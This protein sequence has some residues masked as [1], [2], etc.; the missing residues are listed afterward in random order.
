[1]KLKK[2]PKGL[3]DV[4]GVS[5]IREPEPDFTKQ[6]LVSCA[7]IRPDD[8]LLQGG[9]T[10][11]DVRARSGLYEDN[12]KSDPMDLEGYVDNYG[13]FLDRRRASRVAC[14][15][16]QCMPMHEDTRILSC[17]INWKLYDNK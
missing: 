11:A 2:R 4:K 8:T 16:G 3:N 17:D 13:E 9:L 10:H 6:H 14:K 7:I 5:V 1:M 15:A 12:Y